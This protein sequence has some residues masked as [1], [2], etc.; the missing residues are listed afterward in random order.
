MTFFEKEVGFTHVWNDGTT[1][2]VPAVITDSHDCFFEDTGEI[3]RA[4]VFI[5]L[6]NFTLLGV[7][8]IVAILLL[9]YKDNYFP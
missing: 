8:A 9:I 5:V 4:K 7:L 2:I 6:M 1:G 3:E